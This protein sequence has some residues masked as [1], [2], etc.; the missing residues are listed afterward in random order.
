MKKLKFVK[1]ELVK[2]DKAKREHREFQRR[3]NLKTIEEVERKVDEGSN[4]DQDIIE[5][6]KALESLWNQEKQDHETN[7]QKHKNKWCLEGDENS[8][9]FHRN[10]NKKKR[11]EGIKGILEDGVWQIDPNK[12]KLTF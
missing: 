12:V 4:T 3:K 11:K 5:R 1:T 9:L 2:W 6:E 10:L 8:K 7:K